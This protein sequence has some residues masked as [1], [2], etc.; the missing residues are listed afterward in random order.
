LAPL[1]LPAFRRLAGAYAISRFGE[2]IALVA[3]APAV[4]DQTHSALAVA[5]LLLAREM[6]PVAVA[7]ALTA[8]LD[9]VP[10]RRVVPAVYAA[11]AVLMCALA[12]LTRHFSFVPFL[13][14]VA[15]DG[16]LGVTGRAL[17]RAGFAAALDATG[18]LR[19][20]NALVSV[21]VAPSMAIGGIAGGALVAAG[22]TDLALLVTALVFALGALLGAR[23]GQVGRVDATEPEQGGEWRERL[24]E[25]FAYLRSNRLVLVLLIAQTAALVFFAMTEPIEVPYTRDT[26]A[27]GAGGY[28]ALVAAWGVGVILG[29]IVYAAV[30][31]RR[32]AV[33]LVVA[34]VLQGASFF[35][36]AAAT[37]I[38]GACAIAVVGGAANGAQLAAIATA[39][40]EAIALEFQA[41]VMSIYEAAT[42][43]SPGIGYLI[44]GALG[45][46][47]GGRVAFAAAGAGVLAVTLAA[48]AARPWRGRAS[49]AQAPY[50][51]PA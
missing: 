50:A 1:R 30:G 22:S 49:T 10:I 2:F 42:T 33:T 48:A 20:G 46:L 18:E 39:I 28:G 32:L 34:T 13:A 7:P 51:R 5:A 31:Q 36:L 27:A 3:I 12:L 40:Q 44:G 29:G 14:I 35:G 16:A 24:R 9:R 21:A 37:T 26:L 11:E 6:A 47:A 43:A 38:V 45:A 4:Y 25:G 19:A 23:V 8:R 41:R 17:C 15:V